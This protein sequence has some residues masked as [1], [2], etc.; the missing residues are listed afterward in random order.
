MIMEILLFVLIIVII[1]D[2]FTSKFNILDIYTEKGKPSW[3]RVMGNVAIFIW[4]K[5][6]LEYAVNPSLYKSEFYIILTAA[7]WIPK[8]LQKIIERYMQN[9][10]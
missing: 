1:I 2:I 5:T 4:A 8:L 9:D 7:A 10:K 3:I 6:S